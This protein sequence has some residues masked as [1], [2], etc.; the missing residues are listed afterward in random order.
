[1]GGAF[2][3]NDPT[4][5]GASCTYTFYNVTPTFKLFDVGFRCCFDANPS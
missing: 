4:G 2:N 5:S 1:M 3:T